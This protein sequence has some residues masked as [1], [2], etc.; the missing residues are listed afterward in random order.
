MSNP[1]RRLRILLLT[2]DVG[3]GG[4]ERVWNEH[5][6]ALS[7]YFHVEQAVFEL[8]KAKA[9]YRSDLLLH[10]LTINPLICRLGSLARLIQ[11]IIALYLLVKRRKFDIVISHLEGANLVNVVSCSP[12]K[13]ILVLH[14]S[15]QEDLNH[16]KFYRFIRL[17]FLMPFIYQKGDAVVGVSRGTAR[18]IKRYSGI[19]KVYAIPNFFDTE[20]IELKSKLPIPDRYSNIFNGRKILI[21]SGRLAKQ[22]NQ[23]FLFLIL[24]ELKACKLDFCLVILGDGEMLSDLVNLA[25]YCDLVTYSFF[26]DS[27]H[28]VPANSD[29]YF[30]G[31]QDNPFSWL[32]ASDIFLFPS[33]WEGHPLALCEALLCNIPVISTDC[34]NGPREIIAPYFT[35]KG[36]TLVPI[37]ASNG[38][39]MPISFDKKSAI[40]WADAI[41]FLI[42]NTTK[43]NAMMNSGYLFARGLTSEAILPQWL[44]LIAKTMQ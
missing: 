36:S 43:R 31:Y 17:R 37:Y 38:I 19:E 8:N 21:T 26:G 7:K 9:G 39:L 12:A 5:S 32:A 3:L 33:L 34:P 6:I 25:K 4:A 20:T 28:Q 42:E 2:T 22:K 11:R 10:D 35:V 18:E 23:S 1:Y 15:A 27:S 13:K 44:D 41:E 14:G 29:V 16:K 30:V 40:A 24:Q